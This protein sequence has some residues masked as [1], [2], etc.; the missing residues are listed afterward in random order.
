MKNFSI[1]RQKI[2]DKQQSTGI[3]LSSCGEIE[4]R[5]TNKVNQETRDNDHWPIPDHSLMS[6][7]LLDNHPGEKIVDD[8]PAC[9][10]PSVY[11]PARSAIETVLIM[12]CFDPNLCR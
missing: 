11:V 9:G 7:Q 12:N 5:E 10:A 1:K 8:H 4:K 3:N 2:R 6:R